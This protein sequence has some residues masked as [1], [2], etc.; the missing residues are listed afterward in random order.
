[1]LELLLARTGR[2]GLRALDASELFEAGKLY[3]WVTSDLAYAQGH[4]YD[5]ELQHYLNRLVARA[6]AIVYGATVESGWR[7]FARFFTHTF[8]REF[9]SSWPY[10]AAAAAITI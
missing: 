3:R 6:H 9:R 4:G 10:I 7:R 2:R 1:R 5:P 8:P